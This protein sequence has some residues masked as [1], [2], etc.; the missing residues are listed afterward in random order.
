MRI[1]GVDA[2]TAIRWGEVATFDVGP[3]R[4]NISSPCIPY[5]LNSTRAS[6]YL[7]P[8]SSHSRTGFHPSRFAQTSHLAL[9]SVLEK[10]SSSGLHRASVEREGEVLRP[11]T[12]TASFPPEEVRFE[13][14]LMSVKRWTMGIIAEPR[15]VEPPSVAAASEGAMRDEDE[16]VWYDSIDIIESVVVGV[17]A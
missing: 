17:G 5:G 4:R 12:V 16:A 9:S 11:C 14:G 3:T 8:Q 7:I 2:E 15:I 10:N 13:P 1:C 6:A